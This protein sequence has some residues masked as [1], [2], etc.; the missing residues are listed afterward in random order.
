M[1]TSTG[2]PFTST[3]H[4]RGFS[5]S[6][7]GR[8]QS[9][10]ICMRPSRLHISLDLLEAL[11]WLNADLLAKHAH[12]HVRLPAHVGEEVHPAERVDDTGG[13]GSRTPAFEWR[14]SLSAQGSGHLT[15][16]V[17]VLIV[18]VL[19]AKLVRDFSNGFVSLPHSPRDLVSISHANFDRLQV[20]ETTGNS[21]PSLRDMIAQTGRY[22]SGPR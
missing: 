1:R 11:P 16:Q 5:S 7:L 22:Y 14:R 3:I 9:G 4:T 8:H 17:R 19:L 2:R 15:R 13:P 10:S 18:Q 6:M 21:S 20:L 12:G